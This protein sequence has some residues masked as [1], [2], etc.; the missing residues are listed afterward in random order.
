MILLPM[1][2]IFKDSELKIK[3]K[4]GTSM[5][6]SVSVDIFNMDLNQIY[7]KQI[8]SMKSIL[9]LVEVSD[10]VT[11]DGWTPESCEK[12]IITSDRSEKLYQCDMIEIDKANRIY[13]VEV[14]HKE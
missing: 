14:D 5:L 9:P 4:N 10:T 3:I 12:I 11:L 8:A 2:P 13:S 7:R 6:I 1:L